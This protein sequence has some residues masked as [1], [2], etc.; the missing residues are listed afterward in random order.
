M[1][2]AIA[3]PR[4]KR[5]YAAMSAAAGAV[6]KTAYK[7]VKKY[8]K[9]QLKRSTKKHQKAKSAV[10]GMPRDRIGRDNGLISSN[11]K[12]P[13]PKRGSAEYRRTVFGT[14][15]EANKL[16]IGG[17]TI[18]NESVHFR[19]IAHTILAHYLPKLGD[20][21]ASNEQLPATAPL[22]TSAFIT[23]A[24][25][26]PASLAT[27]ADFQQ[28]S[29]IANADLTTMATLLGTQMANYAH[30]GFFPNSI[31]FDELVGA[32]FFSRLRDQQLGRH[33]ITVACKGRFRFQNVTPAGDGASDKST[34]LNA[35][36]ANPCSGKIYTFRNQAP[37]FASTYS[38]TVVDAA[39]L[40]GIETLQTVQT[41]FEMYGSGTGGKGGAAFTPIVAPPLNPASLFRNVSSCGNVTFPPGG[42]KTY[43]T[44]YLRSESIAKYCQ[45]ITQSVF[46]VTGAAESQATYPPAG[47]SF[48]MCLRPTIKTATG[49]LIRLSYNTEY[50]YTASIKR[51]KPSALQ[52]VNIIE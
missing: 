11:Q 10:A 46:N 1:T 13:R 3:N 14:Y 32:A 33:T 50:I 8:V 19:T 35:V 34:N 12:V 49:E 23:Y 52:V 18:G 17:S 38:A 37:L 44:S 28:G 16:W 41:D 15:Q 5:D 2:Y 22:W 25:D 27:G 40:T 26:A 24:K 51:R 42:F 21:R 20:M 45:N 48:M 7:S 4:R 36:D 29:A 30:S 6:S 31:A 39:T 43:T 9:K 47:D